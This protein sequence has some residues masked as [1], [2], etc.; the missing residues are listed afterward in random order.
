MVFRKPNFLYTFLNLTF[1]LG[2]PLKAKIEVSWYSDINSN[3]FSI[4]LL[5]F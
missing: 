2:D 5:H 3:M 4:M 1:V